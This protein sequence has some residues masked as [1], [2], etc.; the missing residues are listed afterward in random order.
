VAYI[1]WKILGQKGE[2][3]ELKRKGMAHNFILFLQNAEIPYVI[4]MN[5]KLSW[6]PRKFF[7]DY[8]EYRDKPSFDHFRDGPTETHKASTNGK[9]HLTV[10]SL[11]LKQ[12]E[13]S[14]IVYAIDR[15]PTQHEAAELLGISARSI[16][17]KINVNPRLRNLAEAKGMTK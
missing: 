3:L 16:N 14:L 13:E 2:Y 10:S 15:S 9:I 17:Y 6:I 4:V 8:D 12:V 7:E 11:K 5:K 1:Y